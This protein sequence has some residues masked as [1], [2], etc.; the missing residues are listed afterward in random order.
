MKAILP[1]YPPI[2]P[3]APVARTRLDGYLDKLVFARE[4]LA[5]VMVELPDIDSHWVL[6]H[7]RKVLRRALYTRQAM[8]SYVIKDLDNRINE[9]ENILESYQNEIIP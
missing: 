1:P 6:D 9:A 3:S 2:D 7:D 4:L 5:K 8:I